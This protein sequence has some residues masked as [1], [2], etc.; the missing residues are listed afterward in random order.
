MTVIE[1]K[2]D[3]VDNDT[4]KFYDWIGWDAVYPGKVS[5]LLDGAD[6]VEVNINSN[7]G[8]VFAAS[9]I[10]TLL[11]QHS[12]MVTVNIQGLAASA[13]SVIAMAG[14]VVHIS[15]TAQIM[16][17][18]AWTIA[19]GNADDMAHTSEFLDGIDDSIMNAYVVKTGLDKSELSNMMAKET[20]LTA[21]QAVDYGFADDVMD[22]GRPREPVL[23]SIGYPQ[24]SRAVVDRWKKAMASAEAYEK[25]KK[26]AENRDAEIVGKK[27]L[28]AKID[29]L[30]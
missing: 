18:K 30:F 16:I 20:W 14:D 21:N 22:F 25:Q 5:N 6:E 24:V 11:S 12:G 23:N 27:E 28:Q 10:Y 13:A 19:D 4:G 15:P 7:G 17:H 9:E 26:T 1:V 2:A 8:D 29:L 3:I